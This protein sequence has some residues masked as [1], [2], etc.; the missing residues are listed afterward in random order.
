MQDY[1][2]IVLSSLD[3]LF[4]EHML[5]PVSIV[6]LVYICDLCSHNPMRELP[7]HIGLLR[8][9]KV[10]DVSGMKLCQLPG[11][12]VAL[13]NLVKLFCQGCKLADLPEGLGQDQPRL[14]QVSSA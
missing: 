5:S 8:Q 7:D 2:S 6:Y 10:L 4:S 13:P 3:S 11:A 9:L 14:Q 1:S 12:I